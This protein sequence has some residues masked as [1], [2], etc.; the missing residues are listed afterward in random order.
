MENGEVMVQTVYILRGTDP[1][2]MP[3]Y[4]GEVNQLLGIYA[5]REAAEKAKADWPGYCDLNISED[6]VYV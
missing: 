6:E 5:T 4:G 3:S 1:N 2:V